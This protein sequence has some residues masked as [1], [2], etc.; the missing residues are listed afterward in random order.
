MIEVYIDFWAGLL[1]AG[2]TATI[3]YGETDSNKSPDSRVG[4]QVNIYLTCG[5]F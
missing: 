5:G 1:L 3:I 4:P 2:R